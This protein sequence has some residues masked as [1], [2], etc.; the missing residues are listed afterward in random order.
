MAVGTFW[1][2]IPVLLGLRFRFRLSVWMAPCPFS[3]NPPT[4]SFPAAVAQP[5]HHVHHLKQ[6]QRRSSIDFRQSP[7]PSQFPITL[8]WRRRILWE[9]ETGMRRVI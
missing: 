7:S 1:A 3:P 8:V 5:A 4:R 6:H 2:K 9:L